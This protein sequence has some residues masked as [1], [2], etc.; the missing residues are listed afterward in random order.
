MR[1][2]ILAVM[3]LFMASVSWAKD[4][5]KPSS[6][7][8]VKGNHSYDYT[9]THSMVRGEVVAALIKCVEK[10][11][12]GNLVEQ[13][14]TVRVTMTTKDFANDDL[15]V[16]AADKEWNKPVATPKPTATP[17]TLHYTDN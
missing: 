11:K 14:R 16:A 6:V 5:P 10:D 8:V 17:R 13:P 4:A 12:D 3:V 2:F 9:V 1:K 15:L 7:S